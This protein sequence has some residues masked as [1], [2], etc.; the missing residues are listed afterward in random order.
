[1]NIN[2]IIGKTDK[3]NSELWLPLI[4]HSLDTAGIM[5]KIIDNHTSD[6]IIYSIGL[7][8]LFL[9]KVAVFIAFMH[10]IGKM[11]CIFQSNISQNISSRAE[12]LYESGYRLNSYIEKKI[13]IP[14]AFTGE[15]ILSSRNCKIDIPESIAIIIG[16]HHGNIVSRLNNE[17][18][19][20][21]QIEINEEL[22][23]GDNK[24]IWIESWNDFLSKAMQ[25]A[26][27]ELGEILPEINVQGQILLS[28]M[29]IMA[30]W[31]ASNSAYFPLIRT[32]E[33]YDSSMYPDRVENA[34]SKTSFP[35][36]WESYYSYIDDDIFNDKFGFFP[37]EVQKEFVSTVNSVITPG[38]YIL[39][40]QMGV[41]KTEAALAASDILACKFGESGIFFGMP[42]QATSNGIFRRIYDWALKEAEENSESEG[43]LSYSI[44]LA[45]GAAELNDDY[46]KLMFRGHADVDDIDSTDESSIAVYPWFEGNKKALLADFVIGTVDQFLMCALKKRH[47]MLRHIGLAGKVVIIDECHA[48]D[49]YMNV[50]LETALKW[51][52]AYKVP[53]ILLSAT[54]PSEK[55]AALIESYVKSYKRYNDPDCD[56]TK[57]DGWKENSSYPL[58]TWSDGCSIRQKTVTQTSVSI[59]VMISRSNISVLPNLIAEKLEKGGCCVIILNTVKKAQELYDILS[60]DLIPSGFR[61]IMYHSHFCNLDRASKEEEIRNEE[62]QCGSAGG[63][64]NAILRIV[65]DSTSGHAMIRDVPISYS[66]LNREYRSRYQKELDPKVIMPADSESETAHDAFGEIMG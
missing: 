39:E 66:P 63:N 13:K 49:A 46:E 3:V 23:F 10:D 54:L 20:D 65:V 31:I 44:R 43:R 29:L 8:H 35:D 42:T 30:D 32:D 14:H 17:D 37:R 55:R 52:A 36:K 2:K 9:R 28:G 58:I 16:A 6:S 18:D 56:I 50:Y 45:H 25:V 11:T 40:A 57:P 21:Y 1:M 61:I 38:I 33:E 12:T 24:E 27:F 59:E 62:W 47:F 34:W 51:M 53:V 7:D 4:M 41:G 5:E 60:A 26:Q 48:Y 64:K 15:W 19:G 22:V